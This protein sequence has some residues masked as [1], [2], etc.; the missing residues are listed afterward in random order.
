MY[1]RFMIRRAEERRK[2]FLL[3]MTIKLMTRTHYF[4]GSVVPPRCEIYLHV[5][6][7]QDMKNKRDGTENQYLF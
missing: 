2:F 5:T 4:S 6:P 7:T 1:N 3:L